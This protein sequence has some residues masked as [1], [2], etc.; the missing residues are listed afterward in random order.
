M[1][2]WIRKIAIERSKE[3]NIARREELNLLILRQLYL[4]RKLQRRQVHRLGELQAVHLLI[5]EW[6]KKNVRKYNSRLGWRNSSQARKLQF[7][8]MNCIRGQSRKLPS[9]KQNQG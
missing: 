2:L 8:T 6:Y 7:I 5:K 4:T 1:V 3:M 9:Y